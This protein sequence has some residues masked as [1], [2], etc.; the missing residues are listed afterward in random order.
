VYTPPS[1]AV[2]DVAWAATLIGEYP[3]AT[4]IT[5]VNERP[6][7]THLPLLGQRRG[8]ELWLL[9]HVARANP[10]ARAIAEGAAATAIFNGPHAYVSA[11]WYEE[12]Y[13]TV[14]TWNYSVVQCAGQLREGDTRDILARLTATFE[15]GNADAWDQ[16]RLD[17]GYF[18]GQLR[19]IVGFEMR[20]DTLLAK[21]KLSQNRTDADRERVIAKLAA[22]PHEI[23]RA[24]AAAMRLELR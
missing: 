7:V 22:S 24:C 20:V 9:G 10:H 23:E 16:N 12:P 2:T 1:F 6:Q 15:A 8:D 13:A 4:L 11:S 3:F 19:G 17:P 18:E 14:P 21:A 5:V